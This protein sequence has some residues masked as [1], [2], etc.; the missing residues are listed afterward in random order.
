VGRIPSLDGSLKGWLSQLE[1]L[2]SLGA[3]RAV[4][5]HG[6]V[7]VDFASARSDLESY[8]KTLLRETRRAIAAGMDIDAAPDSVAQSERAKWKLFD[9]YH[10]RNVTQAFRELEWE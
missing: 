2:A 8:L 3:R 7:S 9:E 10:G 4:P 5:G 1:V 6:P